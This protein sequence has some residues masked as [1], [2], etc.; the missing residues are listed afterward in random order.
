MGSH[1]QWALSAEL[2]VTNR[3]TLREVVC[4]EPECEVPTYVHSTY[5]YEGDDR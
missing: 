1:V 2:V 4:P 5:T 3:V